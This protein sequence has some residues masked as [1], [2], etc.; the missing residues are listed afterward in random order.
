MNAISGILSIF[1]QQKNR[2]R[3]P[4]CQFLFHKQYAVKFVSAGCKKTEFFQKNPV[5]LHC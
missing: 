4:L 5:F 2:D 1:S 3:L